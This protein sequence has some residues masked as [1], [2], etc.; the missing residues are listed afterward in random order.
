MTAEQRRKTMMKRVCRILLAAALAPA[1]AFAQTYPARTIHLISGVT[2]G[3]ASDTTARIIAEKMQASIGQP[4]IVENKLGAGGLIAASYVAKA[5]PDGY[6]INIY[7]S[8]FTVAPLINP[9]TLDPKDLAPVATIGVV[10]T[11]LVVSTAKNYKSVADLVAAAKAKPGAIVAS[12]AGIGSSTHM[13]LERFRLSAGIDLLE[14]PM[15][16]APDALTEVLT[17]RADF[18]FALPFQVGPQVKE[19]KLRALAVGAAK[20]SALFPDVPTTV[21]AG[22]PNSDYNFWIGALVAAKTPRD[23]VARLNKEINAAVASSEVREKFLKLGVDPLSMSLPDF[24][25]MI[26]QELVSNA[27]LIKSAGIKAE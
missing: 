14:L 8:A 2:P 21:E 5:D 26:K 7:T 25:A 11:V 9:G 1:I 12:T 18:Y 16:G 19:G 23:I 13:Q 20:R 3:S 10:P 4:V 15:K 17:G 22:Y 24:E 27:Q 6:L